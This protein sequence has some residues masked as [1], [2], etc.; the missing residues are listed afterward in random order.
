MFF[1]V[2]I[3]HTTSIVR[4]HRGE[5]GQVKQVKPIQHV[6]HAK[7]FGEKPRLPSALPKVK[8]AG[9]TRK[10]E[11]PSRPVTPRKRDSL[12]QVSHDIVLN[13]TEHA[14]CRVQKN[15]RRHDGLA[16]VE[17]SHQMANSFQTRR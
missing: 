2:P 9:T 15:L 1:H 13:W 14:D 12:R 16:E 6:V 7:N 8:R 3:D 10:K 4:R 5:G 17:I 11:M